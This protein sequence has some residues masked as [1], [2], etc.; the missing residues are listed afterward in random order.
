MPLDTEQH[1]TAC[2]A[3]A[4]GTLFFGRGFGATGETIA[5]LCFNTA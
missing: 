5:E 4:D 3:L 1:P 2:L